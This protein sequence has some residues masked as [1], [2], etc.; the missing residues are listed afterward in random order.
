M[1]LR[2]LRLATAVASC[3]LSPVALAD[4]VPYSP[5]ADHEYPDRLLFGETHLHSALSAD[6][7]GG[8]TR[9]MPRNVY[10]FAR[11]EQVKSSTGQAVKL[12]RPYDFIA[13][14]EHTDGM[15]V[16]TDLIS[17]SANIMADEQGRKYHEAFNAGGEQARQAS[18]D[19]IK[20]FSQ[21]TLSPA[22]NYQPGN[23]GYARTWNDLVQAAEE[24]NE[25][26]RFTALIAYEWTSLVKGNNLHRNVILRDGPERALQ[27]LP[28]TMTPPIGSPDP[29]DLWKWLQSYEDTTGGRVL[30]IPHN[31]NLSN[32]I[33]FP[34]QDD[35]DNGAAF[36]RTY[37]STRQK[38]E[39]LVEIGQTKGDSETHPLLSPD[40]EFADYERWDWANLDLTEKKTPEMMLGEYTR[41]ALKRG[42]SFHESLGANPYK[43]G[44]VGGSDIHTGL[45]TPDDNNFFG[46]FAW[47]EP[48]ATRATM[49]AKENKDLGIGY[50]GWQY[51]TPG[52][53]A[54]WAQANTRAAIFDA[55]QRRETYAT[56]GPRIRV[57]FFGG[58]DFSDSDVKQRD[59]AA[60]GYA[61]GVPMGADLHAAPS[62]DA[63]PGFLIAAMRDPDGANLDR[64]QVVK[65]WIDQSGAAHEKVYDVAWSGDRKISRRGKLPP[66]GDTVD[67]SV[68]TWS[69]TIGAA[70]LATYW[71]DPDFDPALKAFY[72]ARVLEIPTPRWTAYDQVRYDI[73]LP[74]DVV[75][76]T[77]ERAYT[78][79]I[80]YTP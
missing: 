7:G 25:P 50:K 45:T 53:T 39:R 43:M 47:M 48:S 23:P 34:L 75:L 64:I 11:G 12:S 10:R 22:L 41:S 77:H 71:T 31:G 67:L 16:F 19:L 18:Y 15:G 72:Y 68:P 21:G 69:N 78:S 55:M 73:D 74:D 24:Y 42:L 13:L 20:Q 58:Y 9:L 26:H 32:G 8:G 38:W 57:R 52:P 66:V 54:V 1:S 6:A 49:T 28:F 3:L 5:N 80:W 14:T 33:M 30:A 51:A 2:N 44:F 56:T 70:D 76:K 35:F 37:A 60:I 40:D 65:G 79:P 46:A 61:R 27:V 29:R 36:D 62:T 17:G 4:D 59:I 63:T